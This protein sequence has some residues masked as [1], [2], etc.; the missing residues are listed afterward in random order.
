MSKCSAGD[1]E[2]ECGN[3]GCGCTAESDNPA[4]CRCT[5]PGGDITGGFT[6]ADGVL[7]DASFDNLPVFEVA[8]FLNRF[9]EGTLHV[10]ANRMRQNLTWSKKRVPFGQLLDE[11]GL[12]RDP[13][14][15]Q[16]NDGRRNLLTFLMGAG[17]GG[18]IVALLTQSPDE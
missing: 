16:G 4:N 3:G 1:C 12:E 13:R 6:L 7:V 11:L 14:A 17:I 2:I 5:C 15:P 10:P 9:H 18:L 8:E